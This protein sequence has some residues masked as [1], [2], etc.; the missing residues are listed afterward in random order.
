[1]GTLE[2]A[3]L[4][5]A[6][7]P[8]AHLQVAE[9]AEFTRIVQDRDNIEGTKQRAEIATAGTYYWRLGSIRSD[10]DRGPFGDPQR[11]E[12]RPTPEPASAAPS[13]DG[14]SLIFR[15]KGRP[16][17]RQQVQLARDPEFTQIVAQEELATSEWNLPR[18]EKSGR[19]YFRYRTVEPDGFMSAYSQTLLFEVPHDWSGWL[20]LL[21]L[22]L[23]L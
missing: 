21:P 8:Q 16:E 7:A 1:L 23:L 18:P 4:A 13:G 10:G 11:F 6:T 5:N 17:D 20:L 19:Y 15:W 9:D 3:W 2:F 12:L 14:N 22:V